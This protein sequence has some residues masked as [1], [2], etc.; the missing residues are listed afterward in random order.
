MSFLRGML[1]TTVLA[2]GWPAAGQ[3]PDPRAATALVRV[4]AEQQGDGP[5]W[6]SPSAERAYEQIGAGSGFFVSSTGYLVTLS[7]IVSPREIDDDLLAF[8]VVVPFPRQEG[9]PIAYQASLVAS[10]PLAGLALLAILPDRD[11]PFVH[12]GDSDAVAEREALSV[13]GW[14]ADGQSASSSLHFSTHR[15]DELGVAQLL[16]ISG[17]PAP[18]TAGGAIVD[19]AGYVVGVSKPG[20]AGASA[21]GISVNS[22]KEFLAANGL[23]SELP[24][25]LFL[26]SEVSIREKGLRLRLVE[27]IWD[28]WPGRTRYESPRD[29]EGVS[30]RLD[31]LASPLDI[32]ELEARLLSGGFGSLPAVRLGDATNEKRNIPRSRTRVYGSALSQ[33]DGNSYAVEYVVMRV[34]N[35]R[36]VARYELPERQAA[37]NRSILQSSLESIQITRFLMLEV[38]KPLNVE[39]EPARFA[40]LEEAPTIVMPQGWTQESVSESIPG[41]FPVP[42]GVLSASPSTD[43]TVAFIA[44]FWRDQPDIQNVPRDGVTQELRFMKFGLE[45]TVRQAVVRTDEG[46]LMLECRVPSSKAEFCQDACSEWQSEAAPPRRGDAAEASTPRR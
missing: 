4:W 20:E 10:D 44:Y 19:K 5:A 45:Y 12:L 22:V 36:I 26:G 14:R 13:F 6:T 46:L 15:S 39:L 27:G 32:G 9:G 33:R 11:L 1:V 8:E 35:E 41:G 31:R 42:D 7:E 24:A 2:F 34:G 17:R 21:L 23:A 30:F 37:F 38:E 43:Y 16:E 40:S 3:P 28:A 29:P 25:S 18:G